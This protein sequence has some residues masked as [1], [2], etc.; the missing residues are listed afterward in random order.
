MPCATGG[1]KSRER[2]HVK[3]DPFLKVEDENLT[4]ESV[5]QYKS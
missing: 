5:T 1:A 2:C 4:H 3:S